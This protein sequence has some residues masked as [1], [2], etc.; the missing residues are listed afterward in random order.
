MS[1][2][3][4]SVTGRHELRLRVLR[5]FL[6]H[7]LAVASA[8]ILAVLIL[9]SVF[10][11]AVE[12]LL[13]ADIRDVDLSA[14]LQGPSPA[15]PLGTDELGRDLLVRLLYGGRIS[16]L[17]G[18][19][20]AVFSAIIG[21]AIGIVA[22]YF[23]GRLDDLLMRFTDGVIALPILPLLIVLAAVDL[24]KL[25]LPASVA[26]SSDISL[27]RIIVI[28]ALF[29]WTG[30]ARLVRGA[31]LSLKEREFVRAAIAMGAS[32]WRVMRIHIL[33]N[34]ISP[35]VV[36]TTL[37]VGGI[38]LFESVLSFLGL[39]IQPPIPS[40]GNMLTGAQEQLSS[41][42]QLMIWPG[43]MIFVTVIAFNFLGDGLQDALDPRALSD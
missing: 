40:W 10:A 24:T 36:A 29:G 26:N 43:L 27:Y 23:G 13:G 25:G 39:G 42:P 37:S 34:A 15:H 21:A 2:A 19:V 35:I 14:I 32:P 9:A 1:A 12:R 22:G 8:V 18:L 28:T 17:V 20:A 11:P 6:R 41:A 30:V 3:A 5:R 7:R 38:I 33:P 31:T 4:I 16:L